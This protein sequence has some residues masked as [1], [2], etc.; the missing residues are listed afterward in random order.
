MIVQFVNKECAIR[1]QALKLTFE[2]ELYI[3]LI[4]NLLSYCSSRMLYFICV[5]MSYTYLLEMSPGRG[6]GYVGFLRN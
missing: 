4:G 5:L 1:V 6:G 2:D 3:Q